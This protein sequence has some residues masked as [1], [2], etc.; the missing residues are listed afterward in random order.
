MF[1][2]LID[3]HGDRILFLKSGIS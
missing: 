3:T 2:S 1:I